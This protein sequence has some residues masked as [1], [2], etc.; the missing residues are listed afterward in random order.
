MTEAELADA[1]CKRD[2][3]STHEER[4]EKVKRRI[5]QDIDDCVL[6]SDIRSWWELAAHCDPEDR[7]LAFAMPWHQASSPYA[8]ECLDALMADV[9][10]WM[11]DG[12]P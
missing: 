10:E 11:A 7:Y 5:R 1:K 8:K 9:G 6:P 3:D 4:V 12:C 2:E